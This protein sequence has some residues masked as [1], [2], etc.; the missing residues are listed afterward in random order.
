MIIN[1]G[2]LAEQPPPLAV[3]HAQRVA[4]QGWRTLTLM[5]VYYTEPWPVSSAKQITAWLNV[6]SIH[7]DVKDPPWKVFGEPRKSYSVF[8]IVGKPN[9]EDICKAAQS[10]ILSHS[11]RSPPIIS[12]TSSS[13]HIQFSVSPLAKMEMCVS[14]SSLI[15]LGDL[16]TAEIK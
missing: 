2:Q 4:P 14:G 5:T 8:F 15:L 11:Y 12:M 3:S 10:S 13:Q 6:D 9:V 7:R 1:I 16:R